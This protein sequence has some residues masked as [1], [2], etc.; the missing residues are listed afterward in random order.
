MFSQ[1]VRALGRLG[2]HRAALAAVGASALAA[3]AF[4]ANSSHCLSL[5]LDSKT[6]AALTKILSTA[7]DASDESALKAATTQDILDELNKRI[8]TQVSKATNVAYVFA[9]PHANT[10]AVLEVIKSKF[11]E[12]GIKVLKEGVVTGE[13][14]D[15]NGYIDQH[16]YAIAEKST[17]TSG[18]D[19][20]VNADKFKGTFGEDWAT[21]VAEGRAFNALEFKKKFAAF[22]KEGALDKAWDATNV[23]KKTRV[24]LGGGFY[25]GQIAVDGV[26]YYTFNAFFMTMRGKFTAPGTSIHYYVVEFDPT[27]LSCDPQCQNT[28]ARAKVPVRPLAAP[29]ARPLA[30]GCPLGPGRR[31][32]A[33]WVPRRG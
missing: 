2:R 13:E 26:K 33:A 32:L 17:L 10:P 28:P 23:D 20:P 16:Y 7:L 27:K 8:G 30:R 1:G 5:D 21:V 14:I 12:K 18:K 22:S 15:K 29:Q 9:K 6:A 25:C 11:A 31:A 4:A 19:L 3:S 24:K